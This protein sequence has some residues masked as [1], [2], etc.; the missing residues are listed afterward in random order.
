VAIDC[1]F[2]SIAE[3]HELAAEIRSIIGVV[4]HGLFLDMATKAVVADAGGVR[5]MGV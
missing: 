1:H 2:G 4:E 5:V 3:P